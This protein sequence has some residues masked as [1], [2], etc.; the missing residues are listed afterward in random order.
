MS[1]TLL[2]K[3][4]F[5]MLCIMFLVL[6]T[7]AVFAQTNVK[8]VVTDEK[9]E[10]LIGVS[11]K[12]KGATG[13]VSTNVNGEFAISVPE[14]G[15]LTFSY[16]G[17]TTQEVTI[18][19]RTTVN[20]KLAAVTSNLEEVVV[21][22]YGSRKKET[23]TGAVAS[24]TAKDID[25]AHGGGTASTMLAGKLPGV[26]FRQ[27]EGR[28]GS[29]ASIQIRNMG[30]PLFI[31]DGVQ[32]DQGQFNNIS[33][34]DI[35]QISVL[36]D[37]AAAIYGVRAANGVVLVTTK[38]GSG[39][40]RINIDGYQG[41]QNF[42]RF[43]GA[44]RN[45]YD[46]QRYKAE[47]EVNLNGTTPMT[48][49]ELDKWKAGTDP[50]YRSFDWQEFIVDDHKNAPQNQVNLSFT[51][52]EDK[53]NY[54]VAASNFHQGFNLGNEF[55]FDRA[56]LQSNINAKVSN[57][58]SIGIALNGRVE[59]RG[60]PGVPG[61]D[62]Y[63]LP[64]RAV[65]RNTPLERP[66]ANDNPAYLNKIGNTQT[67]YAFLNEKIS[68][69]YRDQWRVLQTTLNAEYQIPGLKGLSVKG[70]YSYY[71]A[72]NL[73]NNFEYTYK[74]YTYNAV[75]NNYDVTGGSSNPFRERTQQKVY[76][77]TLQ[78]QL[79]YNNTFGKHT[80]G[81]TFVTERLTVQNL[82]NRIHSIPVSNNLPLIYFSN[83]D[84]YE[85]SDVEQARLGYVGRVNY[86]FGNKY[87]F[88]AAGR[89]DASYL[90]EPGS[91][92]GYFPTFSAGWRITQEN[93]MK[94]LTENST[95]L[96]DLKIRGSYGILGDDSGVSA[97]LY[98]PGYN[99]GPG[100]GISIL[101]G[102]T[103]TTARDKGKT[104][105][106]I[107]WSK[108]KITDVGF[109]L[110]LF[111]SSLAISGDYFYRKR[112]GLLAAKNEVI[113]P[114]EVGYSLPNANINQDAQYG[115]EGSINFNSKAG[116]VTYNIGLNASYTR[117]KFIQSYNPLFFNSWDR[118]RNSSEGRYSRIDWGY[119]VLGQF[120][121]QEQINNYP[122]NIDGRSN[123]SLLP[124]DLIYKDQNS[125]GKIDGYDQRPIG[126][127]N[128]QPNIN[129]GFTLGAAYKN[130]DFNADFSGGA[131]Y[132][133]FQNAQVRW[134]FAD[135]GNLNTIFEDRWHRENLFDV[136]SPWVAGKYPPL[137]FNQSTLS[138]Y[139]SNSTMWVHNAKFFRAR[140]IELG[141]SMS[142]SLLSK[143]KVR[144]ARIFA[145]VYNL[146]S[147]D[148]LAEY[149]VDPETSN[150]NGLQAPQTRVLNFGLNL[151]F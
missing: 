117:S 101:E 89:R 67:N 81:A 61:G 50:N 85:D 90:F 8:G 48:Q 146:F 3:Q 113:L 56:N 135:G 151:S 127:G 78:G 44:L 104:D 87:Y 55:R 58:F 72:D 38:K 131:G 91:R 17:F 15:V 4:P 52:G 34:S 119:E 26:T 121:S 10:A 126:Y 93:F 141:Y 114:A 64:R 42:F 59:K 40:T 105:N 18:S 124:G 128:S 30:T 27:S 100:Q 116:K 1:N 60:N 73:Y 143:V 24:V 2:Q 129:M 138:S 57:R 32:S 115:T 92:V 107:T 13:G 75:T 94:K 102:Q 142:P 112:T 120:Q 79:N 5:T 136:N 9:G 111:N 11:V 98:L 108:S 109:D 71:V 39:A 76:N 45:A 118:Y 43:P 46:W 139:N 47:A 110:S 96:S 88:E 14:N 106:R 125:D 150:D 144:K 54:Y 33:P 97:Y 12:I 63:D 62:D 35:D 132:T 31:I 20:V 7:T 133:W 77:T 65:L 145:N 36:K 29:S 82:R 130:F 53:V 86:S 66:Y 83:S 74:A 122:V 16:V 80:I 103:I 123:R 140:S 84:L 137:R 28:P 149:S 25:R 21:T 69:V 23:I 41:Y 148:N 19:G 51:G 22:G 49:A 37:G 6:L 134:A 70:L 95:I 147:I 99:Y 68:G